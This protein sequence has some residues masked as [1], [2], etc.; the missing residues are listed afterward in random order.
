MPI[1]PQKGG[2]VQWQNSGAFG[3]WLNLSEKPRE[4]IVVAGQ[5]DYARPIKTLITILSLGLFA[6]LAYLNLWHGNLNQDEGWYLNA[7]RE[8]AAGELPYRDFAYTQA[9]ALPFVYRAVVPYVEADGLM[10]GRLFTQ[11]LGAVSVLFACF[12][13]ARLAP[14]AR[15]LAA[16]FCLVLAGI[17]T[18]QSYY[19]TV[20]KTYGL[21]AAFFT[22]GCFLAAC[23]GR[24]RWWL[25]FFAGLLLALAAATRI[26]AGLALPVVGLTMVALRKRNGDMPWLSFGVGGLLGLGV[27]FLP[28]YLAAPEGMKFGMLEYHVGREAENPWLLKAGF[29]SRLAQDYL[30]AFVCLAGL[31]LAWLYGKRTA[32]PERGWI[33]GLSLV[34]L[35]VTGLHLAA[36]YPYDDYQVFLYPLF[37]ALVAVGLSRVS[38]PWLLPLVFLA[39][40]AAAGSSPIVQEWF[41]E[42]RDRVWWRSKAQ[43]DLA[44]LQEAGREI[45]ERFGNGGKAEL[46]TQDTYLAVESGLDVPPGFEMGPFSYYPEMDAE[47]AKALHLHNR[48]SLEQALRGSE[49]PVAALSGYSFAIGCPEVVELPAS[50]QARFRAL[51]DERYQRAHTM[52][53]FGQGS[54]T[55]EI[56]TR[57]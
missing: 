43:S 6:G 52:E 42:G 15:R 39:S 28:L 13:A 37:C 35:A 30:V 8:V 1:I 23:A 31:V 40:T 2:S 57:K 29:L 32:P 14:G 26:S 25:A 16:V 53:A 27:A 48:A 36:S 18:F 38:V 9:P 5:C 45:R 21:T 41:I 11:L 19:T 12:L 46:L 24:K 10:A 56:L 33:V 34:L 54:T 44:E 17:C 47:R 55:L 50:E 20:V 4:I 7:A 51:V 3:I 49:A 22:A